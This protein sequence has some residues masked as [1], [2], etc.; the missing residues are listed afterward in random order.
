MI[1]APLVRTRELKDCR[2]S[3]VSVAPLTTI[4]CPSYELSASVIIAL[5]VKTAADS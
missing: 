1:T 4:S 5:V 2:P 3:T